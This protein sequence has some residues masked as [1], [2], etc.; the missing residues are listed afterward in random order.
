MLK[1]LGYH[2]AITGRDP[3]ASASLETSIPAV[4]GV[5]GVKPHD[6]NWGII[7]SRVH[8][9]GYITAAH[10]CTCVYTQRRTQV[11]G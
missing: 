6:R 11:P 5:K 1:T 7:S 8:H 2:S 3:K 4:S 10:V 9:T